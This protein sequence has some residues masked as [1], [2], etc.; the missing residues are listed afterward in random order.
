MLSNQQHF[1]VLLHTRGWLNPPGGKGCQS[2]SAQEPG[3]CSRSWAG[4]QGRATAGPLRLCCGTEG[5]VLCSTGGLRSW[6]ETKVLFGRLRKDC[7]R[8]YT[9]NGHGTEVLLTYRI[10]TVKR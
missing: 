10:K 3:F 8:N 1:G 4:R 2:R 6:C 7:V 5:C 9:G